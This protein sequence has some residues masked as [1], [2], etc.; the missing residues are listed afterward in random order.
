M[1]E[2]IIDM[3]RARRIAERSE[4]EQQ[5]G[6]DVVARFIEKRAARQD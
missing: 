5:A 4:A 2:G 6:E 3:F 1:S